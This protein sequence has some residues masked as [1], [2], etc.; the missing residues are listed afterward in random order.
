[1]CG[2]VTLDSFILLFECVALFLWSVVR[3]GFCIRVFGVEALKVAVDN[4]VLV[5]DG[6]RVWQGGVS[7]AEVAWGIKGVFL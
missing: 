5:P 7:F 4:T 2:E 1:M 3:I 6:A